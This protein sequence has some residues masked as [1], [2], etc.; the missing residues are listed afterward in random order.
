MIFLSNSHRLLAGTQMY[1]VLIH[2]HPHPA[3]NFF[4]VKLLVVLQN[5]FIRFHSRKKVLLLSMFIFSTYKNLSYYI[6]A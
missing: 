4:Y 1:Q 6:L 5:Q 2:S 3:V